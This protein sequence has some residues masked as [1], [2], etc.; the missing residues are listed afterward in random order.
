MPLEFID[1]VD[2]AVKVGLG[3]A[4]SGIAT[5]SITHLNHTADNAKELSKRRIEFI[6]FSIEKLEIYFEAFNRCYARLDGILKHGTPPG[7]FPKALYGGY[8]ELDKQLLEARKTRAIALSRL[9]LIGEIEATKQVGRI[10]IFES[11]FREKTIF[12]EQL[13]TSQELKAFGKEIREIRDSLYEL[14][15]SAFENSYGQP[16]GQVSKRQSG[17]GGSLIQAIK[18]RLGRT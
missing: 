5:Y 4:I 6:T 8:V 2:T 12:N 11:K 7:E 1:I 3:A 10:G 18:R 15:A 9:R 14:L 16:H 13:L 17:A